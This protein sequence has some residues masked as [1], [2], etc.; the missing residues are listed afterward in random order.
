MPVVDAG[1]FVAA[2][3]EAGGRGA[4]AREAMRSARRLHVPHLLDL[5]VVSALR[6]LVRAG[7]VDPDRAVVALSRLV[8]API[9]RHAHR[10]LL[11]AVWGFRDNATPYDA[12]YLA[13]AERLGMPLVTTDARLTGVPN[14]RVPIQVVR[15]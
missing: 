1:V 7:R 3:T 6:G 14:V 10:S 12:V 11:A 9:R 2:Y 4:A 8:R 5:E 13:L 15:G